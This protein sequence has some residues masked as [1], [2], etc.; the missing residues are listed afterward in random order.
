MATYFDV[1]DLRTEQY[2]GRMTMAMISARWN[3]RKE[4]EDRIFKVTSED[5]PPGRCELFF[6]HPGVPDIVVQRAPDDWVPPT[7]H[8]PMLRGRGESQ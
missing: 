3:M 5:F 4:A 7:V 2:H 8:I 6:N 1:F